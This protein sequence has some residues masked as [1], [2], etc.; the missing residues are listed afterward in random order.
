MLDAF[1]FGV[2]G[3]R[4]KDRE[5]TREAAYL[6]AVRWARDV[7]GATRLGLTGA[8]PQITVA[9]SSKPGLGVELDYDKL[10][11]GKERYRVCKYRKRDDEA[12]MWK[13]V[14]KNWKRILPR[15]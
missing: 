9:I 8:A 4:Y 11:R 6:F 7:Y 1:M 5:L 14:D 12:E 15:W 10:A 13:H 3:G 2:A